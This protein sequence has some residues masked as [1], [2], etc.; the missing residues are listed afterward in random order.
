MTQIII[1]LYNN[2]K[3]YFAWKSATSVQFGQF[4]AFINKRRRRN[5]YGNEYSQRPQCLTHYKKSI[6]T[7]QAVKFVCSF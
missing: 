6:L 5:V 7:G 4:G 1:K 2:D 3:S